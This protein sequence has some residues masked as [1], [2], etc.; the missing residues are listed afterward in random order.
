MKYKTCVSIAEKDPKKVK[1]VLK[2][3]LS[4]SDYAEIRFDFLKKSDIPVVLE[5]IK[6]NL[7]RCVCTLRPKSEG[8]RFVGKEDEW[9]S[10]LR[11]IAE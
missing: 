10:I 7:S 8:G 1:L 3:A 6:K 5:N 9:K 2:K 4:K 11:L